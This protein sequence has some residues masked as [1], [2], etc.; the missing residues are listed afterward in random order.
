MKRAT[1]KNK[2]KVDAYAKETEVKT[3]KQCH[4]DYLTL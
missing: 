4:C 1:L 3:N 2:T